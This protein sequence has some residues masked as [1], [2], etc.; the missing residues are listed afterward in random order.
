MATGDR[1]GE[2]HGG[3]TEIDVKRGI[4]RNGLHEVYI[5]HR[6]HGGASTSRKLAVISSAYILTSTIIS[7]DE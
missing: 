2:A 5:Y 1:T 3:E 4:G 6:R 7:K